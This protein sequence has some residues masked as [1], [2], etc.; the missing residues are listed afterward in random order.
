M[1]RC[2]NCTQGVLSPSQYDP[3]QSG[4]EVTLVYIGEKVG[5]QVITG[6]SGRQYIFSKPNP[7]IV[8]D[9]GDVTALLNLGYFDRR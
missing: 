2:T 1:P 4:T 8:A 6:P 9:G 3:S 5:G 7:V